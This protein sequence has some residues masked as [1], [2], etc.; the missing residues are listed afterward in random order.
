[1]LLILRNLSQ[2]YFLF[3][4]LPSTEVETS[5]EKALEQEEERIT[6]Q[7]KML[8]LS[9]KKIRE[10]ENEMLIQAKNSLQC[11]QVATSENE[12]EKMLRS[13]EKQVNFHIS[14]FTTHF[15]RC[16]KTVDNVE[17]KRV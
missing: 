2:Q 6:Y 11:K 16:R 1:M 10:R 9:I 17:L 13:M 3:S 7:R 12:L 8:L 4:H 5:Y 14:F 15:A